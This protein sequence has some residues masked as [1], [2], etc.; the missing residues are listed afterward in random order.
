MSLPD[1]IR[2][3]S[4]A[5]RTATELQRLV[6]EISKE[7]RPVLTKASQKTVNPEILTPQ[8]LEV[9]KLLKD[10]KVRDEILD[11]LKIAKK[12]FDH[13]KQEIRKKFGF[14]K[15]QLNQYLS[16]REKIDLKI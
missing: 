3:L 14:N 12:T 10:G 16:I 9:L 1:L 5:L 13:Y 8:A 2:K 15:H 7:E 4:S 11:E 6:N